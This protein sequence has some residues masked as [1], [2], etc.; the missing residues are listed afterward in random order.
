MGAIIRLRERR[1]EKRLRADATRGIVP[2]QPV[3]LGVPG[4]DP[5]A[6]RRTQVPPLGLREY[7]YPALPASRVGRKPLFWKMLGDELV[8]FRNEEGGVGVLS[9][10]CPHR[11]ASLAQGDCFFAGTVTCPYHAAVFDKDGNCK[12]FLTEG[13]ASKMVGNLKAKSY[14][15]LVL[16]G[17]VFIWMGDGEPVDPKDDIPPE[18]F[19]GESTMVLSTYTYW[20]TSWMIAIENQND[21]HNAM[22]VHRNSL[23]QLTADRARKRTPQGPRS[24]LIEDRALVPLMHNQDYYA[25]ETGRVPYQLEYPG[26]GK[27]PMH[28]WRKWV[29]AAFKPYYQHV[30]F[31]PLRLKK[32]DFPYKSPEEWAQPVGGSC[33]H[34]PSAIRVNFGLWMYTRYAVPVTENLSRIV[35]FHNRRS[36][37]P[38]T[39]AVITAWFYGYFNYWVHYNFSGM[40][41]R[42]ASPSRYWTPESLAP[43]DSHLSLLRRLVTER[44]RDA[45]RRSAD[46]AGAATTTAQPGG[47]S[48]LPTSHVLEEP[49]LEEAASVS[50]TARA[51]DLGGVG[52]TR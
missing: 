42:A 13:P 2:P 34:L 51:I 38:V 50:A 25:D 46:L 9:D 6:D 37:N 18:F 43:T 47:S 15:S 21:S 26:V 16:R 12:A 7:W 39:R 14:P 22:F 48:A 41:S 19:E 27:W 11:G 33:W 8:L 3:A 52:R 44:S 45:K 4:A 40:D 17:W 36:H 31:S 49:S 20:P 30:V 10:V 28:S 29:W 24:K 32:L 5:G 1:I 35:Y 23:M